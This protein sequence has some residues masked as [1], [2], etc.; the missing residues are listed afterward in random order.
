MSISNIID[1]STRKIYP[2]L[3]PPVPLAVPN[4]NQVLIAGNSAGTIGNPQT[5]ENL[6]ELETQKIYQGN[7]LQL[8]LGESGD[9]VLLKGT[10]ALGTIHVGN[11]VSIE[12]LPVGANGLVLKANS[13]SITG[14]GVEWAVDG[15]SGITGV[16]AGANITIDNTAPLTP[17]ISLSAPLTSTLNMGN[18]AITDSASA[19]GTSGQYL[20]AGTGAKTLWATLPTSVSTVSAGT[21][22]SITGTAS[23]PIVNLG[24]AG[25]LT[26][27]LN[28]G[29]QNVQGTSS[30]I[31]LTNGGS[32]ANTTATIGFTSADASVP[33]T[34]SVL[35]KTGLTVQTA[36]NAVVVSPTSIVKSGTTP[37]S[38]TSGSSQI[39]LQG[40]GGLSDGI[41]INQL[42]GQP[43]TLT[44]SLSNVKYY[45]DSY[46]TNN[47]LNT[48]GVPNPQVIN[49][50][51]LLN[52]LGLSNT[53]QWSDF[54]SNVFSGYS[55]F[56]LDSNG[57]VWL[58]ENTGSNPLTIHVY[59]QTITTLLHS[60]T[61]SSTV[62]TCAVH[63]F[64]EA[65]GFM[66]IGGLFSSINGNAT[67]QYSITRVSLS[68]YLEDPIWSSSQSIYGIVNGQEVYTISYDG[69]NSLLY[70]GGAFTG[71][72]NIS[73]TVSYIA[74]MTDA[75]NV[76]GNQVYN[77]F[78][79]GVNSTVYAILAIDNRVLVG[80]DFTQ[81]DYNSGLPIG[82]QYGAYFDYN[83]VAWLDFA[84]NSLNGPVYVI[85]PTAY[86]F[87]FLSGNFSAPA[88]QAFSLYVEVA[89]PQ[90]YSDSNLVLTSPPSYKQAYGI[91][92]VIALMN[93]NN[94]YIDNTS[95][96]NWSSLGDPTGSGPVSGI[97]NFAGNWK[98][99]YES[100]GHVRS[101]SVL[102]HSCIFTGSFKY[103]GTT[104]GNYTINTR[105]VSQ[106]FVGDNTCSFWSIIGQGVGS[107][108]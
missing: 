90:N 104:Y 47:D 23:A 10:T 93:G 26:S 54:G 18:V 60:L 107:F 82:Y 71:F 30:Q 97:N 85:K 29:I 77:E 42:S 98:V 37:L 108:S 52:N 2:E 49:Q 51:L 13:S 69:T 1:P 55:A 66:F 9:T 92:G 48:V 15:T 67:A 105:N 21:N 99:I 33:T 50:R 84:L 41:Q 91:G 5:I 7:Y 74:Q 17:A 86:S 61:V 16:S 89:T 106:S 14:L 44:T 11:G 53:N 38:I 102:P 35:F 87:Y 34:K 68:S 88:S 59:D 6:D 76:G 73:P 75:F 43:T 12:K 64:H 56:Q 39:V 78:A 20:T 4:L 19:T 8:E 95:F 100:Y 57:N 31:T 3:I 28:V 62:G 70:F 25:V 103:D 32:Q 81:V 36:T 101:Y 24:T 94:L 22:I 79:N 46:L 80:G 58:A 72:S 45:P 40:S 96:Q 27:T 83:V 63:V 65:G